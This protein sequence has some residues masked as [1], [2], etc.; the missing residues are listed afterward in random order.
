LIKTL[1]VA[2]EDTRTK[3]A[4]RLAFAYPGEEAEGG[5]QAENL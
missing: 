5:M 3:E 1:F 4:V 2:R